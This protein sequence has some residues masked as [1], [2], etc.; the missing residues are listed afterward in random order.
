MKLLR[1]ALMSVVILFALATLMG[2]LM[3]SMVLV[4]RA[5]NINTSKDTVIGYIKDINQWKGWMDGMDQASILIQDSLHA[6]LNQTKVV[7]I[8]STDSSLVSTWTSPKGKTQIASF[9]F[10]QNPTQPVT[11][12]QWQFEEKVAWY[13]WERLGTM[14]NDKIMGP[15]MENNLNNLK[16][17]VEGNATHQP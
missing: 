3:P 13:P 9:R 14:M 1:F 4:S 10:L 12:V 2:L 11:V 15:M 17:L 5:V 16:K 7:I 6:N 8:E